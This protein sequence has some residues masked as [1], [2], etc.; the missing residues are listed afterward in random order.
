MAAPST[1]IQELCTLKIFEELLSKST[2]DVK[3]WDSMVI[4]IQK[5][6]KDIEGIH[7]NIKKNELIDKL[8]EENV[9]GSKVPKLKISKTDKDWY[10]SF[11]LQYKQIRATTNL[12][13]NKFDVYNR[14]GGFMDYITKLIRNEKFKPKIT[15]KD[16]W[17]PADIWLIDEKGDKFKKLKGL[18]DECDSI[19]RVN[20]ILK[21]A[22]REN[23]IVGISLKKTNGKKLHYDILN[24]ET[25]A[26]EFEFFAEYQ[27]FNIDISFDGRRKQFNSVTSE[28]KIKYNG[29]GY[30]MQ[31]KSN[32]SGIG[33]VTFEY[34]ADGG[35]AFLGKVPK[36]R[37]LRTIKK[38]KPS[39]K[40]PEWIH[41]K[42][43]DKDD[44]E[45]KV[46]A[47]KN[48]S[49]RFDIKGDIDK[50]VENIE[51]SRSRGK[52]EYHKD[53]LIVCQIIYFA[54]FISTLTDKQ[55]EKFMTETFYL[56]QKKGY[57]FGTF[58]KLY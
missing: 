54:H 31:V 24:L 19:A 18:L 50:L 21:E 32:K 55:L 47:I 3:D 6:W 40:I 5:I 9:S 52:E 8:N 42:D 43:F 17:N 30:R 10:F 1:R 16:S 25:N 49:K 11:R 20:D 39:E 2:P 34:K 4:H 37:L 56:S 44:F 53:N 12:P 48:K 45:K 27:T 57:D 58:G 13:N 35:S 26:K 33:N 7:A 38:Y 29:N 22:F 23:I 51:K 28:I 41:F 15:K 36:D 46:N 14:D